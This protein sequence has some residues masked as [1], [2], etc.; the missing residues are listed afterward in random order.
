[1]WQPW[2]EGPRRSYMRLK[3]QVREC[4]RKPL[5]ITAASPVG[6]E[7]LKGMAKASTAEGRRD[8]RHW[9]REEGGGGG[10]G[11]PNTYPWMS[12]AVHTT[13]GLIAGAVDKH[14]QP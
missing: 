1:M 12:T 3:K 13:G 14:L 10:L 4:G 8:L 6:A 2:D 5:G 9:G 11:G 7:I